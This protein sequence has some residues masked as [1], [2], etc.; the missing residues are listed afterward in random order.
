M[1]RRLI[2]AL[3]LLII[4]LFITGCTIIGSSNS[5][6]TSNSKDSLIHGNWVSEDGSYYVFTK[7]STY[8]WY[9]S[10]ED[11]NDNYQKG[12]L[13]FLNGQ[14]AMEEL[15]IQDD[16]LSMIK[17]FEVKK[18][19]LYSVK[20]HVG[21]LISGG[22]DRSDILDKDGY[23]WLYIILINENNAIITNVQTTDVS[24]IKRVID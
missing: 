24:Q 11:T 20:L 4:L 12:K 23:Y 17:S 5:K 9:K 14:M 1:K 18:E 15:G 19:N 13:T 22:I 16:E 3:S 10:I 21:Q 7:N 2:T 8:E 6:I